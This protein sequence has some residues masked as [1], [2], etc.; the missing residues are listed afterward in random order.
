ML[1]KGNISR[2]GRVIVISGRQLSP[3][4]NK[5]CEEQKT[6]RKDTNKIV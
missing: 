1:E 2:K 5:D 3:G 6:K 4:R